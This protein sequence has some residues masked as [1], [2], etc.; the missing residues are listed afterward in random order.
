MQ[1]LFV[2]GGFADVSPAGLTILAEQAV[3]V[4][5]ITDEFVAGEIKAAEDEFAAATNEDERRKSAERLAQV[6]TMRDQFLSRTH[7]Q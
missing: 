3:P 7:L 4:H 6:L 2:R 1:R 5:E